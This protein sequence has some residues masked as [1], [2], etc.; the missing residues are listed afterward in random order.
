[1][2]SW[3]LVELTS[4]I[5]AN[6]E[7]GTANDVTIH[8]IDIHDDFG[9][10]TQLVFLIVNRLSDNYQDISFSLTMGDGTDEK[11]VWDEHRVVFSK[12]D[13]GILQSNHAIPFGLTL[14]EEMEA[15]L[16]SIDAGQFII[17][18]DDFQH[19]NDE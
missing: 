12:E 14:T 8:S 19:G 3:T 1:M 13:I 9:D 17:K 16:R 18:I 10:G 11:T 7:L 2:V 4:Y 6:P 5:E 15:T